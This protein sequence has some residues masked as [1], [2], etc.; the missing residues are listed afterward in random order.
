MHDCTF[1]NLF[2]KLTV[3]GMHVLALLDKDKDRREKLMERFS[4][5]VVKNADHLQPG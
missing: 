4:N 1:V 2:F 5:V 3:E